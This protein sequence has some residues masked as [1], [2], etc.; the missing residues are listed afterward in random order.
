[1]ID[2]ALY[3]KLSTTAGVTAL[4]GTRIYPHQQPP[5][6]TRTYPLL[7]YKPDNREP[8]RLLSG[9]ASLYMRTI[10]V[11]A[12]ARTYASAE[13]IMAAVVAAL[14]NQSGTWGGVTIQGAFLDDDSHDV[15]TLGT[16]DQTLYV[17]QMRFKFWIQ[18]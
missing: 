6:G 12:M 15:E 5:S 10:D 3:G 11:A 7:A 9:A 1:M 17:A 16:E 13:A 2:Q 18:P 14:D 8:A 4:V